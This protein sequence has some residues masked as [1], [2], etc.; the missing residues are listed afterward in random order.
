MHACGS[1]INLVLHNFSCIL[2]TPSSSRDGAACK[3]AW[4]LHRRLPARLEAIRKGHILKL[5]IVKYTSN[6]K[7][8][9]ESEFNSEGSQWG[10]CVPMFT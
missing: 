7:K 6:M 8:T 10:V 9:S 1:T 5:D 2:L 4:G 3:V